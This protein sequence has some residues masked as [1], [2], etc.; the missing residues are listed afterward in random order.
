MFALGFLAMMVFT[1]LV[2]LAGFIFLSIDRRPQ[3]T[4][5]PAHYITVRDVDTHTIETV[6]AAGVTRRW[7][8][9]GRS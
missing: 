9:L 6:D 3:G 1:G 4:G 7:V 8:A 2:F 5:A